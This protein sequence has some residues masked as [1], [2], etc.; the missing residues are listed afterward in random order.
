MYLKKTW[1][2]SCIILE[3]ECGMLTD[4][5]VVTSHVNLFFKQKNNWLCQQPVT[6]SDV[7]FG[8]QSIQAH[9]YGSN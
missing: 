1:F 6:S 2:D 5:L 8:M 4:M 7:T 9:M 3:S